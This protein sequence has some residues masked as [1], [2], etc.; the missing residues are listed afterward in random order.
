MLRVA[1]YKKTN[2]Q[3]KLFGVATQLS[4]SLRSRIESSWAHL[5]KLEVL[6]I[7]LKNEDRYALLYGKTGRPNFS[8]ARVLGLCLLQE[9]NDLSDQQ[10]LDAF[11]FDLRWR[12]ALEVSE[13][14]EDYLSRR[15]L[16][17]FRR[18]LA[19]K[20][21]EMKLVRNVFDGVRDSA[22]QNLG[23]SAA[24]Q[25]VD[26]THVISNIRIRGRLSLFAN[27]LTVF[28][29][30]LDGAQFSGVPK[31]IQ[32][33][34]ASEPEGW[35][36]LGAA[37]QKIKVQEL[38]QYVY[39][40][41]LLFENDDEVKGREPYQLL[42]RLFSE[43]CEF[44]DSSSGPDSFKVQVKKKTEGET[45]QSPYDPDASYGH[46]GA[47]YSVHIT[48][49]CQN[50]DKP[51]IITDY[52]VHG[53]SRSDVGK[54][55]GVIERLDEA[56]LKPETL[57][58][59][60]G[61]PSVPSAWKVKEQDI[62]FMT[63][64]N[65]SRLSD[66]I[67]GRDHF[68]FDSNGFVTECP[69]GHRPIDHR[70]LSGNNSTRRSLHAIFRGSVCRSCKM[71]DQCPVRTPNH[72]HRGCRARD[73]VGDFRLEITAEI[74][75]RD[76]MY[77]L[78]QTK[79]WKDRYKI[80]SGIE[81]TNSELKRSHGLGKLRVRRTPKVCFAVACKV[82]ACNI[83]RWAKAHIDLELERI[84]TS[85]FSFVEIARGRFGNSIPFCRIQCT[86]HC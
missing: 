24:N 81:A 51:E 42:H 67:L 60:G 27:T 68:R 44:S 15:S 61:Y 7:L 32:E 77:S 83:K 22:I 10:A 28:L 37:E 11:S 76:E 59:D 36:G 41:L 30:S 71:L 62:E 80:R 16:V 75:L 35:F 33:W 47:G 82:I 12:Y 40:L 48:E 73:T 43:Q 46:K 39:E 19:A 6:P 72:R 53:A 63:P 26:S 34:H 79:E 54:A 52:E 58:A 14:E 78:Q 20:D 65:R 25:R 38:A 69:M 5:F 45:L 84:N 86:A 57:F 31:A 4:S 64:V 8:V 18:R 49:T 23:V 21:P 2:P 3:Q 85:I 13:G 70:I 9:W 66:E 29:R 17:E 56:G 55:V 74:R 50:S 1:M